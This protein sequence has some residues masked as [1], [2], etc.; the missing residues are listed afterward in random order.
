ME[1]GLIYAACKTFHGKVAWEF[2]RDGSEWHFI[3][4]DNLIEE[5]L[6]KI[7]QEI[8]SEEH[9]YIVLN[10][11]DSQEISKVELPGKIAAIFSDANCIIWDKGFQRLIEFNKNGIY[12]IGTNT[13]AAK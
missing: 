12:R 9:L 1:S 11:S 8:F 3:G 6:Q 10:R 2:F 7:I 13:T 5:K 4:N